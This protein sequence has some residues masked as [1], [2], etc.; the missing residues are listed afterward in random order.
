MLNDLDQGDKKFARVP[1]RMHRRLLFRLF[2]REAI[3]ISVRGPSPSL[4]P[5]SNAFKVPSRCFSKFLEGS[6]SALDVLR[7][8]LPIVLRVE[9]YV[10]FTPTALTQIARSLPDTLMEELCETPEGK[11]GL[12]AFLSHFPSHFEMKMEG[13]THIVCRVGRSKAPDHLQRPD[14]VCSGLP[15]EKFPVSS[16]ASSATRDSKYHSKNIPAE[17]YSHFPTFIVPLRAL[18]SSTDGEGGGIPAPEPTVTASTPSEAEERVKRVV[19]NLLVHYREYLIYVNPYTNDAFPS[20]Y[21]KE[22]GAEDTSTNIAELSLWELGYAALHPSV[23]ASF[24][25]IPAC[26]KA[27]FATN[28]RL[29]AWRVEESACYRLARLFPRVHDEIKLTA[30]WLAEAKELLLPHQSPLHV[31]CGAPHLFKTYSQ[32]LSAETHQEGEQISSNL[33]KIQLFSQF[34]LDNRYA[35]QVTE[36]ESELREQLYI[37]SKGVR[38]AASSHQ[39]INIPIDRRKRRKLRRKLQYLTNR[40]PF[41]D[42]RVLA[43][44]VFD[45]LPEDRPMILKNLVESLPE[46]VR[47]CLPGDLKQFFLRYPSYFKIFYDY[48][49]M[50]QRANLPQPSAH[51]SNDITAEDIL[52]EIF[53]RYPLRYHPEKGICLV[54]CVSG[55]PLWIMQRIR[56]LSNF[57]EDV[58]QALPQKVEILPRS[59]NGLTKEEE[60]AAM[61]Q[62]R[63]RCDFLIPFRFVGNLRNQLE[64][65]YNKF[66]KRREAKL[67]SA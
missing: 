11:G 17:L 3:F 22:G 63:G 49:A 32:S 35:I 29:A 23:V 55:L 21:T 56:T 67:S 39:N 46:A 51:S 31:L 59:Q 50:I 36:S 58:L 64:E 52:Q 9:A 8:A 53:I 60:K 14:A 40:T 43:Q 4:L 62:Y 30:E 33:A 44:F 2:K 16:S 28:K 24:H 45:A 26:R 38:S 66:H 5:A 27:V 10:P 37:V 20:R 54:K 1:L 7:E 25:R 47:Y 12:L 19:E 6:N 34:L 15:T 65:R 57:E 18:W 61:Q 41:F 42:D 48:D 13:T